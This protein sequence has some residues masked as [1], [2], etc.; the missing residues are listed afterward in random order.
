MNS[1]ILE[2]VTAEIA[3]QCRHHRWTWTYSATWYWCGKYWKWRG[4][5]QQRRVT[6]FSPPVNLWLLTGNHLVFVSFANYV[7]VLDDF[8]FH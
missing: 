4:R 7:N 8:S 6:W 1:S 5:L 2:I 3:G